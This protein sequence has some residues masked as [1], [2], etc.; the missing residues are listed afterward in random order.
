MMKMFSNNEAELDLKSKENYPSVP[1]LKAFVHC[2]MGLKVDKTEDKR[3]C[4]RRKT[5]GHER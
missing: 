1:N 5:Q 2:L 4:A 3:L